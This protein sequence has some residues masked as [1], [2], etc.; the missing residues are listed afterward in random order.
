MYPAWTTSDAILVVVGLF[1]AVIF[2]A[3]G[4]VALVEGSVDGRAVI[5]CFTLAAIGLVVA[6]D[7]ISKTERRG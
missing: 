2:A 1:A 7:R 4:V 6:Y 3:T 5:L